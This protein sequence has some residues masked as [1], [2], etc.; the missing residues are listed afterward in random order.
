MTSHAVT[1]S[2]RVTFATL[3]VAATTVSAN[4]F[5]IA[6]AGPREWDVVSYD[7][8]VATWL[9][10]YQTGDF[11]FQDYH[12]AV[13]GCCINTGG[14]VSETQ[15]C[16]APPAEQAQEAERAPVEAPFIGPDAT[17][18]MPPPVGPVG[19]AAPPPG[20]AIQTP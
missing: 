1:I 16:V 14:V 6:S 5:T 18:W 9:A 2:R 11:T 19:P 20:E 3:C 13:V 17:L 7:D 15:G 10:E 12:G 4:A 8:C